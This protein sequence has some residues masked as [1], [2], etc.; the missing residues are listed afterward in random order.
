MAS[1]IVAATALIF[2]NA[3]SCLAAPS[4]KL[5]ADANSYTAKVDVS[6]AIAFNEDDGKPGF[7]T[8]FLI[9]KKRGWLITNAHVA[10]RSP[11]NISVSFKDDKSIPARRIYVDSLIDIAIIA[12]PPEEIGADRAEAILDCEALPKVGIPITVLGHPSGFEVTF[13]RGVVTEIRSDYPQ[14]HVESDAPINP[15][16]SGGPIISDTSGKVIAVTSKGYRPDKDE[17]VQ[18]SMSVPSVHVCKIIEL[19]KSDIDPSYRQLPVA[20][21]YHDEHDIPVVGQVYTKESGFKIGDVILGIQGEADIRNYPDL[22]TQMRGKNEVE[23][24]IKRDGEPI[25]LKAKLI[26]EPSLLN[27]KAINF[28]GLII[29]IPW[30]LDRA[31]FSHEP[32]FVINDVLD[33]G[34]AVFSEADIGSG[35]LAV[36]NMQFQSIE[37]LYGYLNEVQVGNEV[38]FLLKTNSTNPKFYRK[39]FVITLQKQDIEWIYADED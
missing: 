6:G 25:T 13:T 27:A 17:M 14:E 38:E 12:I 24:R 22:V 5:L 16:N 3:E 32:L 33:T 15:G 7:A 26:P 28:S 21:A 18:L 35:I 1:M 19:L 31:E 8:A 11:A 4:A 36:D 34:S 23:L 2:F 30:K 20:I 37:D 9:D 29:S 39:Y 10:G